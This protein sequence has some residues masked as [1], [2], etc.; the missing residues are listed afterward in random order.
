MKS[1]NDIAIQAPR[2]TVKCEICGKCCFEP[3]GYKTF[4]FGDRIGIVHQVCL[5][6][7]TKLFTAVPEL[8]EITFQKRLL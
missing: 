5:D 8:V 4:N 6:G 7:A 3:G 2:C 1:R